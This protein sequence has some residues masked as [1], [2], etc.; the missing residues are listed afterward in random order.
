MT[1]FDTSSHEASCCW[2]SRIRG[3]SSS[4]SIFRCISGITV[5]GPAYGRLHMRLIMWRRA[6]SSFWIGSSPE[7][8]VRISDCWVMLLA[9]NGIDPELFW[10]HLPLLPVGKLSRGSSGLG[11]SRP[12]RL[13]VATSP[14]SLP[15]ISCPEI[16]ILGVLLEVRSLTD[17]SHLQCHPEWPDWLWKSPRL[18]RVLPRRDHCLTE[19][20]WLRIQYSIPISSQR[21]HDILKTPKLS[22]TFEYWRAGLG[23]PE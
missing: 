10:P 4:A 20:E 18:R 19:F 16:Q 1:F 11:W 21:V 13:N 7:I 15:W 5:C 8:C 14:G 17:S 22:L 12:Q 3:C 2:G 23:W 9:P 6:R